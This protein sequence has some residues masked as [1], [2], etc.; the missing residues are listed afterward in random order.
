MAYN[1]ENQPEIRQETKMK[2]TPN[3]AGF[4]A[5][6]EDLEKILEDSEK[7]LSR[8]DLAERIAEKGRVSESQ[9]KAWLSTYR[10]QI[11]SILDIESEEDLDGTPGNMTVYWRLKK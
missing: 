9:S 6:K 10:R 1:A 3:T 4:T 5:F 7:P 8:Q 2:Q 11:E